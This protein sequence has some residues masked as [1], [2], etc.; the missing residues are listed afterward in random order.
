M[1][2]IKEELKLSRTEVGFLSTV[3]NLGSV[4]AGIPAGKAADRFGER[5]VIVYA[6]VTSGLMILGM[7]WVGLFPLGS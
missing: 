4:G 7:N 5:L 6:T 1:P 3:L 2:F